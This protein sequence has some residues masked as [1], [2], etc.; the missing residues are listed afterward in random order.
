MMY[1][2]RCVGALRPYTVENANSNQK[3][4]G[5]NYIIKGSWGT[6]AGYTSASEKIQ[7]FSGNW[8]GYYCH[9]NSAPQC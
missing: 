2:T 9:C 1:Q 8:K 4:H 3:S 7:I 5:I 6:T